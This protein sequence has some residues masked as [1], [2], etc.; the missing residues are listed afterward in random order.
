MSAAS[1]GGFEVAN[2]PIPKSWQSE[3]PKVPERGAAGAPGD[4]GEPFQKNEA[5][6]CRHPGSWLDYL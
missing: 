2:M 4:F 6:F 3:I 5:N 1:G